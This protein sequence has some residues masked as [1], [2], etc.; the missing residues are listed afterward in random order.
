VARGLIDLGFAVTASDASPGMVAATRARGV[1]AEVRRWEELAPGAFGTVLC[2]G[3][4]LTHARD[5][6]AV[7]RRMAGALRPGGLLVLTSR[8]WEAERE[9]GSRTERDGAVT[10]AWT[11]PEDW[12]APHRL[13]LDIGDV[14]VELTCWAFRHETLAA[15]LNAAGLEPE[16]STYA[17]DAGRYLV[18]AR[19]GSGG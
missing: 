6:R 1:P 16:V 11:I 2:V 8:N 7:L 19:A 9:R 17:P 10:R 18:T 3:N 13:V 12:D 4:S 5:R 15:D 14:H